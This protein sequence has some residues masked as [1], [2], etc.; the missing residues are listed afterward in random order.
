[1]DSMP[2]ALCMFDASERLVVCNRQYYEMYKLEAADVKA[3]FRR[4]SSQARSLRTRRHRQ[5][6]ETFLRSVAA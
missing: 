6:V 4:S 5:E 1:M 2:H 3:R